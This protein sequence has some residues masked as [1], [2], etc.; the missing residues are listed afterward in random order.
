MG[1]KFQVKLES[2]S[3]YVG[4]HIDRCIKS[5]IIINS[6]NI[7]M[8]IIIHVAPVL[9]PLPDNL[10]R[11]FY[12]HHF[13][14]HGSPSLVLCGGPRMHLWLCAALHNKIC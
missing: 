8:T 11:F 9:P 5:I 10:I 3:P 1:L 12:M 14:G 13:I 7:P 4:Q 2:N 6:F